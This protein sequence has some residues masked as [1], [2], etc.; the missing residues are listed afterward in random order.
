MGTAKKYLIL[1]LFLGLFILMH[2]FFT[3]T[4][5][6]QYEHVCSKGYDNMSSFIWSHRGRY[7]VE[8]IDGSEEAM[9]ALLRKGI[10]HFDLDIVIL[11]PNSSYGQSPTFYISHP[12][13][14]DE[15]HPERHQKVT[16][17]LD[18]LRS[19]ALPPSVSRSS[20]V[21]VTLEPKFSDDADL[22][23]LVIT[24]NNHAMASHCAIITRFLEEAQL[25]KK[26]GGKLGVA[27]ALRSKNVFRE[28][29]WNL[30]MQSI[31]PF[32]AN[33]KVVIMPDIQLIRSHSYMTS[34]F[35]YLSTNFVSW[36]VDSET[37]LVSS[38][39]DE[40]FVGFVTNDPLRQL[41]VLR[42]FYNRECLI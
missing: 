24:V 4:I 3:G 38:L 21:I 30:Q 9:K 27:I 36:I 23:S 8:L 20:E 34:K 25:V 5:K 14:F 13:S 31:R 19:T 41:S 33:R 35:Q 28:E 10:Y 15:S 40:S 39:K 29:L 37:D 17:F 6:S 12:S 26:Y 1:I 16:S 42:E 32:P 11:H 7:D 22:K 2:I 18:L